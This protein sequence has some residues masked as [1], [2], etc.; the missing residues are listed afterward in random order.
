MTK[1]LVVRLH[2]S[3][4]ETLRQAAMRN[5][6]SQ[7]MLIEIA[8]SIDAEDLDKLVSQQKTKVLNARNSNKKERSANRAKDKELLDK[9]KALPVAQLEKLLESQQ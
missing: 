2:D 3:V 8:V 6:I 4:L 9:L 7:S 5:D 1:N